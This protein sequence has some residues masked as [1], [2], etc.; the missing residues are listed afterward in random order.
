MKLRL[1]FCIGMLVLATGCVTYRDRVAVVRGAKFAF[2]EGSPTGEAVG[3]ELSEVALDIGADKID[4]E[5]VAVS[6]EAADANAAGIK[7]ERE[8]RLA[9]WSAVK[10]GFK[11]VAD[12]TGWGWL[13][14]VATSAAGLWTLVQKRREQLKSQKAGEIVGVLG[15]A[16]GAVSSGKPLVEVLASEAKA[17]VHVNTN[18]VN[19][20]VEQAKAGEI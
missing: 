8:S 19:T 14:T 4:P 5:S 2:T 10:T 9:I 3:R 17:L 1:A 16:V 6:A 18:E 20:A 13:A 7:A 12:A 11:W 15:R